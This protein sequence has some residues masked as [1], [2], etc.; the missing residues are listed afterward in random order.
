M[1]QFYWMVIDK[2]Q[3]K[4]TGCQL[5]IFWIKRIAVQRARTCGGRVVKVKCEWDIPTNK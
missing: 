1:K 4:V 3:P 5:P 2:K